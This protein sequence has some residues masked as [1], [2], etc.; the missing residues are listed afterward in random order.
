MSPSMGCDLYLK[1]PVPGGLS[2]SAG[3]QSR[4]G[5]RTVYVLQRADQRDGLYRAASVT[6]TGLF[7]VR[8]RRPPGDQGL[9]PDRAAS[10][11]LDPDN[12]LPSE[13]L[14]FLPDT[15]GKAFVP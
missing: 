2:A 10:L 9:T 15:E 5:H 4:E 7:R 13:R 14:G 1:M 8:N 6:D 11:G 3:W 12:I